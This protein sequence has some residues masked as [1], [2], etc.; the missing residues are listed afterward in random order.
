MPASALPNLHKNGY[1]KITRSPFFLARLHLLT[2]VGAQRLIGLGG[3]GPRTRILCCAQ[4]QICRSPCAATTSAK[5]HAARIVSQ[6]TICRWLCDILI[7]CP[8][9]DSSGCRGEQLQNTELAEE[10]WER[11]GLAGGWFWASVGSAN[12]LCRR[13][14]PKPFSS[15]NALQMSPPTPRAKQ[16]QKKL[17]SLKRMSNNG[18][19]GG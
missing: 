19:A 15:I 18:R 17:M 14:Q 4:S 6:W 3:L 11:G 13:C 9:C 16:W 1:S 10:V 2:P 12:G 8:R 5:S 7:V